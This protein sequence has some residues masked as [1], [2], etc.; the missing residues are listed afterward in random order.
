MRSRDKQLFGHLTPAWLQKSL[1]GLE[2]AAGAGSLK[3]C[4]IVIS[5]IKYSL[6][7]GQSPQERILAE[8]E[9]GNTLGVRYINIPKQGIDLAFL[10]CRALIG[11]LEAVR[12]TLLCVGL[13][14]EGRISS[15]R[16]Y[17][18]IGPSPRWCR[19]VL[20]IGTAAPQ[21]APTQAQQDAIRSSCQSDY[22]ALLRQRADGRL[23]GAAMPGEERRQAC[24][25]PASRLCAR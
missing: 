1:A 25:P 12:P 9:A 4:L 6:K 15:C 18:P 3:D 23:G 17:Q 19:L 21:A 13:Q 14:A 24:R 16:E 11:L 2:T 7:K 10:R 22:P 8:L 20:W 5:H